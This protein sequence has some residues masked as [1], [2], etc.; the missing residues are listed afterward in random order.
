[1][2]RA[3]SPFFYV[4]VLENDGAGSFRYGTPPPEEA[5][6]LTKHSVRKVRD[7]GMELPPNGTNHGNGPSGATNRWWLAVAMKTKKYPYVVEN[8]VYSL[9]VFDYERRT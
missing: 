6:M 4:V 7:R 9:N 1:L 2:G 5:I 8:I 3:R